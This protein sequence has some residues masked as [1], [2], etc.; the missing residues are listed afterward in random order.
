MSTFVLVHGGCHGAWCWYKM[1]PRL[2]AAGHRVI[3][4]DLPGHGIDHTPVGGLSANDFA[5]RVESTLDTLDEPAI[6][7]GHSMG[8]VVVQLVGQHRPEK[9][10]AIVYLATGAVADGET[11]MSDQLWGP[12]LSGIA[13]ITVVD[14]QAGTFRFTDDEARRIFYGDCGADDIALALLL[15]GP[16]SMSAA[17]TRMERTVDRYGTLP[18]YAIVTL[19]DLALPTEVQRQLHARDGITDIVTLA[20]SHSAFFSHPDELARQLVDIAAR[21][22]ADRVVSS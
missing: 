5:A 16:E 19:Q 13:S 10:A 9:V 18:R 14:E 20:S 6:L 12:G 21:V 8:G 3:A 11:A 1:I 4:P 7:V 17:T 2:E 22:P 15:L